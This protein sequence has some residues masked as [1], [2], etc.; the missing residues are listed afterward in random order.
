[1]HFEVKERI[2]VSIGSTRLKMV[3]K[4]VKTLEEQSH[5]AR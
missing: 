4:D 1:M 5:D 3:Q 2:E